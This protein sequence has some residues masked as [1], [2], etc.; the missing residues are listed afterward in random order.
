M[1]NRKCLVTRVSYS[2]NCKKASQ[3]T[4]RSN[5]TILQQDIFAKATYK[6]LHH[7]IEMLMLRGLLVSAI[8]LV[9]IG[10]VD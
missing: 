6:V 9:L 2:M 1:L 4:F 3:I 10:F 5:K 7:P 8:I